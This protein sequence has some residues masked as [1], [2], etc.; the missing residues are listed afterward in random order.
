MGEIKMGWK[1][2]LFMIA[3]VST[4]LIVGYIIGQ[5][6]K[7][8]AM[9]QGIGTGENDFWTTATNHPSWAIEAVQAQPVLI[10]THSTDCSPC[11]TQTEICESVY[12]TYST[13]IKYYDFVSGVDPQAPACFDAYDPDGEAHYIPLT[14]V[15]TEGPGNTIIWHSWEG[16]VEEDVLTEWIEY[17]ITYHNEQDGR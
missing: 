14:V 9:P 10:F 1:D 2:Y 8:D 15:L 4:I 16:V 7:N 12:A 13:E 3:V 6:Q 17:A 5:L 11:I